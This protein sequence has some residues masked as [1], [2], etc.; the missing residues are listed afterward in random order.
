MPFIISTS[1]H[2]LAMVDD[3][4]DLRIFSKV[5]ATGSLSGAARELDLSLAVVSKRLASME[6]WLGVR[7]MHRGSSP[8][9]PIWACDFCSATTSSTWWRTRSNSPSASARVHQLQHGG[10]TGRP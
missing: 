9:P 6:H 5:V 3:L 7:L 4:L 2:H 8:P 10:A 1:A